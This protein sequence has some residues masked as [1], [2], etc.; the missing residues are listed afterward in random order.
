MK[1]SMHRNNPSATVNGCAD[2]AFAEIC[3]A[4]CMITACM[5]RQNISDRDYYCE[6]RRMLPSTNAS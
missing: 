6:G 4:G 5:A 1:E 2:C 3:N